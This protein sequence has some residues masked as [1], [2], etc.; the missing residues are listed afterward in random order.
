MIFT[1]GEQ[2]VYSVFCEKKA[3]KMVCIHGFLSGTLKD[4]FDDFKKVT[5]KT[6]LALCML[7]KD[8]V[9]IRECKLRTK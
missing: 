9:F 4:G 1:M 8:N 6:D 5:K 3:Q 2:H 7:S